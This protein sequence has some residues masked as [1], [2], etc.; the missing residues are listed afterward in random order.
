MNWEEYNIEQIIG[1]VAPDGT[2]YLKLFLQDYTSIFNESV[3]ANCHSKLSGYLTKYKN[4]MK[5]KDN[6]CQWRLKEKYNGIQLEPCS[7]IF[8]TN[9]TLTD[10]L[11]QQLFNR[12]GGSLF[13][14]IP[15]ATNV[16]KEPIVNLTDAPKSKRTRSKKQ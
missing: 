7:A 12:R 15:D 14:R 8:L 13:D 2:R 5:A 4:R 9:D 16:V 6:N 1:G 3:C 10:E 11:A